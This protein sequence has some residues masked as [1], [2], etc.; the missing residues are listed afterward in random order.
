MKKIF[1]K[2]QQAVR[3]PRLARCQQVSKNETLDDDQ[4]RLL[5]HQG[6]NLIIVQIQQFNAVLEENNNI[7]F[8]K[9]NDDN[10]I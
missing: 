8:T 9:T 1:F 10:D 3:A 7:S 2:L 4:I 6:G 5:A